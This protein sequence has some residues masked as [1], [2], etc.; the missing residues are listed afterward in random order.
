MHAVA[1]QR[2]GPAKLSDQ[3]ARVGIE[4][5]LVRIETVP[6][7]RLIR[8]VCAKA[9]G[10]AGMRVRQI[11]VPYLIRALGQREAPDFL[12]AGRIEQ[13]QLDLL[14]I[15]GKHGEVDAEA[16]PARP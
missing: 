10:G 6:V 12:A 7:L 11:T 13:A 4:Q 14:G 2:I 15:G 3:L 1:K 9:V 5:Q 16:V 8:T